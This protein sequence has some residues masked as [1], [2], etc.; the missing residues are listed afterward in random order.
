DRVQAHLPGGRE[1]GEA[2]SAEAARGR[3]QGLP[4]GSEG[5]IEALA[6]PSRGGTAA[7][8]E[9]GGENENGDVAQ[10]GLLL[11]D[12]PERVLRRSASDARSCSPTVGVVSAASAPSPSSNA[13]APTARHERM[14]PDR[15]AGSDFWGGFSD[16]EHDSRGDRV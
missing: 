4:G 1:V 7:G 11:D 2:W 12:V 13:C 10:G 3:R 16:E 14:D 6:V 15:V 9:D 5:P 8:T